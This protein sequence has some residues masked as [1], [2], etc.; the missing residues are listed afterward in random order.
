MFNPFQISG[1]APVGPIV[2]SGV[3]LPNGEGLDL[4]R[5]VFFCPDV[6][7]G[8]R[9]SPCSFKKR[10]A[11]TRLIKEAWSGRYADAMTRDDTLGHALL[12]PPLAIIAH[13]GAQRSS[14]NGGYPIAANS[15]FG[16]KPAW[17]DH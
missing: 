6:N 2:I 5:V 3:D 16:R 7:L 1:Y 9:F 12:A 10:F 4:S 13:V 15:K 11:A 14:R 17:R 8:R